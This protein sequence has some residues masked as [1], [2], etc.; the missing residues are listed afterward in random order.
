MLLDVN[1]LLALAWPNHQHHEAATDWFEKRRLEGWATCAITELGF[2]RISSNPAFTEEAKSP[3]EA[4]A[5]LHAICAMSKHRY[6]TC[7][8]HPTELADDWRHTLGHRQTTD[9][10]LAK[11]AARHRTKLAT[12]DHRLAK[13]PTVKQAVELITVS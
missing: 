1:V 13:H 9:V 10:Y 2:V 6:V 8:P 4:S 5:L 3:A 11:V 12:F 7:E